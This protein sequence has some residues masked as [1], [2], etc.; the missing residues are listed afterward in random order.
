MP[1]APQIHLLA[2]PEAHTE[3]IE[4]LMAL[5]NTEVCFAAGQVCDTDDRLN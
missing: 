4:P 2:T 3:L 1:F 5:L